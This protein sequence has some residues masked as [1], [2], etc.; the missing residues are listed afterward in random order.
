MSVLHSLI[1]QSVSH[2]RILEH[3]GSGGMGVVYKAEDTQLNRLVAIKFLPDELMHD[4]ETFERFRREARTASSLNHANICTIHEIGEHQGRPFIVM[5]Y[6]H[7]QTLRNSLHGRPL[8][9]EHLLSLGIEMA[10]ALDA[11]H[12]KGIVHRDLKPGNIIITDRGH[13]KLLDFGLATPALESAFIEG[14]STITRNRLTRSGTTPGTVAYMSPEQA[15]GKVVDARSD[16]FSFGVVLYEAATGKLPF[17]G[18]TTAAIFDG[19]LNRVP[20]SASQLNPALPPEMERIIFTCL[21]KDR[22]VRYQ[23]AAEV[24]AD[25]KRLKRD[26]D[27]TKTPITALAWRRSRRINWRYLALVVVLSLVAGVAALR[28]MPASEP[29]VLGTSQ[30]SY[31]GMYKDNL[32]SDGSRIY[33]TEGGLGKSGISQVSVTGGETSNIPVPFTVNMVHAISADHSRLLVSGYASSKMEMGLWAVPLPAGSPRR[34]G[35]FQA[36]DGDWSPDQGKLAFVDGQDIYVAT[37][38]GGE[39]RKL[40]SVSGTPSDVRFSPDSQRLRY[41]LNDA[42]RNISSLWEIRVDGTNPHQLLPGWNNPPA[43]CCGRWTADGR[44]YLFQSMRPSGSSVW[45][46]PEKSSWFS[47]T[48]TKP[49]QLTTGPLSWSRPL[50]SD[51]GRKIFA[52]GTLRRGELV[53]FDFKAQDWLPVNAGSPVGEVSFSRDAQSVAWVFYPDGTLWRSRIDGSERV[54]LTFPPKTAFLPRWSP[55]GNTIAYVAAQTGKPW[56]IFL[57]PSRGGPERE[58]LSEAR[59]EIDV[60]WSAD[61]K[62]LVFGR[63]SQPGTGEEINIQIFELATGKSS[64]IP[65]SE[66]LFSPRWSPDGR[67]IAALS[68]DY[69]TL[70]VYNLTSRKW[71]K[72]A[73]APDG[74]IAYPSWSTDSQFIYYEVG[75]DYLRIALGQNRPEVV[76]N[77]KNVRLPVSRW[78]S[79]AT[80]APDGSPL[81]VRDISTH[82]IYGMD[83]KWP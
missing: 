70:L 72:W 7:G 54:Q 32:V 53:R 78:G 46:L 27:S 71:T 47:R 67:H 23:S 80:V 49:L 55:D 1:Q 26:T 36:Q 81:T 37:A 52:L 57:V 58:L 4:Q 22:E 31:G 12:S 35:T 44:Y 13:A 28:L 2:Y 74:V 16:L 40:L 6:L 56:K 24:R 64:A 73:E 43:E 76:A 17:P 83:V 25:L 42:A 62:Q 75:N 30:I 48:T 9:T 39:P 63:P 11:A 51:D 20:V 66:N 21:E 45:A 41:T 33:Y 60:D 29:R 14:G 68:A 50:P 69:K 38:E 65:G 79:W 10:D 15:L 3:L 77:F 34:L 82:E 59:N 5:E 8:Q 19:I 61:G 18:D